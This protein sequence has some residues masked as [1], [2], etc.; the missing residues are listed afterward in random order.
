M[1][2]NNLSELLFVILNQ[3]DQDGT[4]KWPRG[5]VKDYLCYFYLK[6]SVE[7]Q[8]KWKPKDFDKVLIRFLKRVGISQSDSTDSKKKKV[9]AYIKKSI[10]ADLLRQT[11][12]ALRDFTK[13]QLGKK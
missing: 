8:L 7:E 11:Q 1:N 13:S 2:T 6:L 3:K 5:V 10:P 12:S 9:E 4:R